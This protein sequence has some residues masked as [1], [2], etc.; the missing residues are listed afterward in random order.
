[1]R[2]EVAELELSAGMD[3][4]QDRRLEEAVAAHL[5]TCARCRA[6]EAGA[7]HLR[8]AARVR[9]ATPVPDLV[10]RI[11][12]AVD[13]PTPVGRTRPRVAWLPY[14]AAFV[15]GAVVTGLLFGGVPGLQRGPSPALATEIP[16]EVAAATTEIDSFRATFDIL[17][18][19]FHPQIPERRFTADIAFRAPERFRARIVDETAYPSG[20]WT[21][22]DFVLA[23]DE[24]RWSI[25]AP[26][27]CPRLALPACGLVGR[28][29]R[30][31]EGRSPFDGD[32]S[33]PTDIVLP[34]RTL[35]DVD[36]VDVVEETRALDRDA[37]VVALDYH[38]AT[39]LFAYLHAAGTWRPFFPHD[40]VLVTLDAETWFPLAYEVRAAASIER[41]RWATRQGLPDEPA[42]TTLFTAEATHLGEGPGASWQPA[43]VDDPT[44]RDLG[45]EDLSLDEI[46]GR[47]GS[48]PPIPEDVGEL[49]FHR[50]GLSADR[51][52][53]SYARGLGWLTVSG[54]RTSAPPPPP[55]AMALP[56]GDGVGYYSPATAERGRQL[57]I[58]PEGWELVLET[59][60]PR[61]VLLDVAASLPVVGLE[62]DAPTQDMA[63][64]RRALDSLLIPT[65]LPSGYEL[66]NVDARPGTV[67]LHYLRPGSELDGT[68]IRLHQTREAGLPPPLD[69]QVLGVTVRGLPG[70]YSA[71][72][73]ELE[74]VE[75]GVYRSI[76]APA[77]DLAGLLRLAESLEP[78]T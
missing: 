15:A 49:R 11:M 46:S 27:T 31:V 48:A 3:G 45:F 13:A 16:D 2:C 19:N 53:V 41:G 23:I 77:F 66:W 62:A 75:D 21:R 78:A 52:V 50:S 4:E 73:A 28:D 25:D 22:N 43:M 59:N 60:L 61:G 42:G 6:F 14:A 71:E 39:P 44:P 10:P 7:Q 1:M 64:A 57:S 26:R 37:V 72:R 56:V 65:P 76:Q 12:E 5:E 30:S 55:L 34:V 51:F 74:W 20:A 9:A 32:T 54:S 35:V 68:G 29:V 58:R 40:E 17:E 8:V 47:L 18:V 36:R 63:D 67:T 38:D 33:I 69:L 24:Q 70:R